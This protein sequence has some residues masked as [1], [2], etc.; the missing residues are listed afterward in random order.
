M[1][2]DLPT[3]CKDLESVTALYFPELV[4]PSRANTFYKHTDA[5]KYATNT[6]DSSEAPAEVVCTTLESCTRKRFFSTTANYFVL[7]LTCLGSGAARSL[8]VWPGGSRTISPSRAG[9]LEAPVSASW[10]LL[11]LLLSLQSR[12][13]RSHT[14]T[15]SFQG[16]LSRSPSTNTLLKNLK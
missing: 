5:K 15:P 3:L 6:R 9:Y 14:T 12:K 16:Q 10:L 11:L 8:R 2:F 7:L 1:A 13:H 4:Q